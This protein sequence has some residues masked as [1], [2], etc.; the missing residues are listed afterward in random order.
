M[1]DLNDEI[2]RL[3]REKRHWENQIVALGGANY[4]R[5]VAMLDD[6]GKEV[7]GTKGYKY[8]GRAKELPGVKELFMSKKTEEDEENKV[9]NYYKK[10][11]NQGPAY[12]GDVDESEGQLLKFEMNAEEEG[13]S[14]FYMSAS[15]SPLHCANVNSTSVF[16]QTLYSPPF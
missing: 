8:F 10:F 11:Q 7:P 16:T 14:S 9:Q 13:M 5:N 1:R 15:I 6:D 4:R 12:F 3:L 2:N